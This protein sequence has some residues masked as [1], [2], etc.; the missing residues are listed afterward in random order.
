MEK[1][2]NDN[3][4]NEILRFSH[5]TYRSEKEGNKSETQVIRTAG[6]TESKD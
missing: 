6:T 3:E 5:L 1:E 2:E 4:I